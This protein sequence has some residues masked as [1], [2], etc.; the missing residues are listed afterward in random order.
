MPNS[1]IGSCTIQDA[2]PPPVLSLSIGNLAVPEDIGTAYMVVTRLDAGPA[3]N[4]QLFTTDGTAVDGVDYVGVNFVH[5]FAPLEVYNVPIAIINRLGYQDPRDFLLNANVA[6][7]V[8]G[9]CTIY[10]VEVCPIDVP[11]FWASLYSI[12]SDPCGFDFNWD[13]FNRGTILG[14]HSEAGNSF[15]PITD[16]I[17][18]YSGAHITDSGPAELFV[19]GSPF[20]AASD[21]Y[22][23]HFTFDWYYNPLC[24]NGLAT[25]G[26]DFSIKA[27]L[28][29]GDTWIQNPNPT[30]C[31]DTLTFPGPAL[32]Y[33]DGVQ[34]GI[35]SDF[36][37]G[38]YYSP[39]PDNCASDIIVDPGTASLDLTGFGL[40]YDSSNPLC[41]PSDCFC[42]EGVWQFSGG[43]NT[44]P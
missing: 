43:I 37:L 15:S 19:S 11:V 40:N 36:S 17:G 9:T 3:T 41:N 39:G 20:D 32:I 27:F 6:P 24:A 13:G 4:V 5:N 25:G 33:M 12:S 10:S 35:E 18:F 29:T 16:C 1:A 44:Y 30:C 8:A 23:D 31:S 26:G 2:G 34:F 28:H 21:M 7:P 14:V 22:L 42:S 38:T